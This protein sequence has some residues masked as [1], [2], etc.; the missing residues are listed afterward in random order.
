MPMARKRNTEQVDGQI[1]LAMC[2]DSQKMV[3][4]ANR[5]IAGRQKLSL[6]AAK[7]IRLA[8]MQ[9]KPD[10]EKLQPYLVTVPQLAELLKVA[11]DN[12]YATVD[13]LT[14]EILKNPIRIY[15]DDRQRWVKYP[16]VSRCEYVSGTG[17]LIQLNRELKPFL[18]ALKERYTQYVLQDV[19]TMRSVY[20]IRLYELIQSKIMQR[21]LPMEG[22]DVEISVQEIMDACELGESYSIFQNLR[23]RV[24]DVAVLEINE[25]TMYAVGYSY[26]K[27]SR[28]V[29]GFKFHV[30]MR[31]HRAG[32]VEE[33]K[34]EGKKRA[35]KKRKIVQQFKAETAAD[36]QG[37]VPTIGTIQ[38]P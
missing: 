37:I 35:A 18:L 15:S 31:Y 32:A 27:E 3:V 5:M 30:N 22:L 12:L 33:E 21:V 36:G 7:L 11:P 1:T 9:I 10:D 14:D 29:V 13:E 20:A 4:Q 25:K 24:V 6:N 23:A 34:T 38:T 28:K 26:L 16:W 8:V 2:I 19:L 17:V